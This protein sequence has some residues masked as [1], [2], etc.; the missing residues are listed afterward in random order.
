MRFVDQAVVTV[1]AGKGGHGCVSFRREKFI[2]K[3]GPDGGDGGHGGNVVLQVDSGLL[4]LYDLRVKRLY[5]AENGRPGQGKQKTGRNGQDTI[6]RVPP[7]TLVYELSMPGSDAG[8]TEEQTPDDPEL[9]LDLACC[10]DA[11]NEA[12]EDEKHP[13]EA[14]EATAEGRPFEPMQETGRLIADMDVAGKTFVIARGGRGGKGNLHFKT[15]THRTPRFAQPGEEAEERRLRLELKILAD[16]GLLGMP[17]AGKS[18]LIAALSAARPKIAAYPF[19]T[20]TPNLGVMYNALGERMVLADIPGLVEGASLGQGLGH[21]FLRHVE[22]TRFLVHLLSAEDIDR[23][24]PWRGFDLINDE[25]AAYDA[26]LA[27]KPQIQAINK[28]DLLSQD[29]VHSL[30]QR[31]TEDGR[32][33]LFISALN[34]EG[35]EGLLQTMWGMMIRQHTADAV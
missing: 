17:N 24:A 13:P 28:I 20:L 33:L 29:D 25:L 8:W 3:G 35:L 15:S 4:T 11:D 1:R 10:E 9:T 27:L 18:T 22:R 2:P 34:G 7:G 30:R 31:A 21:R 5:Q 26:T 23:D 19:T 14:P 6:V 16:C 32:S 12:L